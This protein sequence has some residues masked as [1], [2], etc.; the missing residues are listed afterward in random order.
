MTKLP[1]K[2]KISTLQKQGGLNPFPDKVLD[3]LFQDKIFFDPYDI[4]QVKYELL[5]KVQVDKIS[6]SNASKSFGF[7]R[8]SFYRILDIFEKMGL[9]GL[10]PQKRGPRGASK[11]TEEIMEFI[12]EA[13]SNNPSSKA[14]ELKKTIEAKFGLLIHT[15]SIERAL[16]KKKL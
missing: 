10:I 11:L 13:V 3:Q 15:R 5:R 4:V 2:N 16:L 6:I 8:L 7:S 12:K 9:P 1:D 14:I